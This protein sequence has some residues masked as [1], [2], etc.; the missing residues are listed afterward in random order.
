MDQIIKII[1]DLSRFSPRQGE[2]EN[3][4]ARYLESVIISLGITPIIQSFDTEVPIILRAELLFDGVP[5]PCLGGS[6]QSGQITSKSQVHFS[7]YSDYIETLS[8]PYGPGV[9]ISKSNKSLLDN[10][11]I[12]SGETVVNKHSYQSRN[13]LVGNSVNPDKIVF[14]HYDSLGGGAVDNA[15]SVAVC[16]H[17]ISDNQELLSN[18]LFVFVGNEELSYDTPDYWGKGYRE[19]EKQYLDLLNFAKEIIVVDGVGVTTPQTITENIEDVFPVRNL[20]ALTS[21]TTWISSVQSEVL[22][23]YHCLED[24]PDKLNQDFLHES[25]DCLQKMLI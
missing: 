12:V 3:K 23:C 10:A 7:P 17:L 8:Y 6:F 19:F 5:V 4:T 1:T 15:G 11:S 18:N 2:N 9:H 14:A 21:K 25:I 20:S 22:K 24:T 16:L 13:I